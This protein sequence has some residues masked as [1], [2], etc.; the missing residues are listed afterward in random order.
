MKICTLYRTFCT[1]KLEAIVTTETFVS[2]HPHELTSQTVFLIF[3][4]IRTSNLIIKY[5][6]HILYFQVLFQYFSQIYV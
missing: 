6:L 1:L 4:T 5:M 3:T 2:T